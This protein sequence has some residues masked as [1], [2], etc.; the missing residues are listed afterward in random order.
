M[1]KKLTIIKSIIDGYH[2]AFTSRNADYR[3]YWIFGF[4]V[5]ELEGLEIDLLLP[6]P[7]PT[8]AISPMEAIEALARYRFQSI[9]YRHDFQIELIK[10]AITENQ[11]TQKS[12]YITSLKEGVLRPA[13]GVHFKTSIVTMSGKRY[14]TQTIKY[15][16][17]HSPRMELCR[18]PDNRL[19]D[20]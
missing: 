5:N 16:R 9:V 13:R 18:N 7:K 2:G 11:V 6:Y 12:Q 8:K 15:I 20:S 3:G 4:I 10:E 17:P 19:F 14:N 1:R